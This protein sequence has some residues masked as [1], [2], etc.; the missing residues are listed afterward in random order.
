MFDHYLNEFQPTHAGLIFHWQETAGRFLGRRACPGPKAGIKIVAGGFTAGYFGENLLEKCRFL[1]TSY[2]AT[3]K[4]PMELLLNG[5]GADE[6]PNLI[7]RKARVRSNRPKYHTDRRT[8]SQMSFSDM[9]CLDQ[10][11]H[12]VEA[13]EKKARL[14]GL[15]RQGMQALMRLLRREPQGIHPA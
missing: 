15:S 12:Y 13:I 9:T 2:R 14:P 4:R 10:L 1:M 3:L 7:H 8:F 11:R 6:I 5:A